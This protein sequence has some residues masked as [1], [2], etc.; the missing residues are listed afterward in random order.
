MYVANVSKNTALIEEL[1]QKGKKFKNTRGARKLAPKDVFYTH[2][3][4][5]QIL[6]IIS[7]TTIHRET[8]LQYT[9]VN[10]GADD[11]DTY[12]NRLLDEPS[13]NILSSTRDM[14]TTAEDNIEQLL[15]DY[16]KVNV[17]DLGPGNGLPIRPTLERL[18]KQGRLNRY[19][20]IDIS[21]DMLT[22]LEK[23]IR[24]WFGD[25]VQYEP[26]IRDIS[27]ER[28]NDIPASEFADNDTVNIVFLL[29]GT[30]ANFR[31]P[32][33]VLQVISNSMR[34]DDL[35]VFSGY[36]DTPKMR[37]YFDYYTADRKVPVQDGLIL[38]FLN[39]DESL[40]D[41][42]QVF[43]EQ[44]RAR[45]ISII[46]KI[47][48]S[49]TIDLPS[50]PRSIELVKGE[51]IL[52]WR[53]WHKTMIEYMNQFDYNGFDIMLATQSPDHHYALTVSKIRI[54]H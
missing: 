21:K 25:S 2:Y 49:I 7:Q 32:D 53:H 18:L 4:H 48:L 31:S 24:A 37:R 13:P 14:L 47:D 50:G 8:P 12:A 27:Y 1:V 44:K 54:G 15:G 42:E 34:P 33:Q 17:I 51:P 9:Y 16:K 36:L 40:Y 52:I 43:N 22:I 6:D 23:N 46:P 11:W 41:V 20:P 28:F 10:G 38:D 19:I 5:K 35:F 3:N 45:S 39:I 30:L 29:G 26:Y